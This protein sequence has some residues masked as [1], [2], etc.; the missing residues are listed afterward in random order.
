MG[1]A[2]ATV[3]AVAVGWW[4]GAV[5]LAI[6]T[7]VALVVFVRPFAELVSMPILRWFF[8]IES[9]GHLAD[10]PRNGGVLVI[11]NHAS[12]FDPPILVHELP[13]ETTGVMNADYADRWYFWFLARF[14]FRVIRVPSA[15]RK[16]ETPEVDAIVAALDRGQCV[17]L[18]PEGWL[19][20]KDEVPLRR[21]GQGIWRI[22]K[23][24]PQTTVVP[25]WIEGTWGSR[26]SYKDGPPAGPKPRDR[27]RPIRV[28]FGAPRTIP[29]ALLA[30]H[31]ATRFELMSWV[32]ETR[33][34][35]GLP[36]VAVEAVANAN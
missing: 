18:F 34:L 6:A 20:R 29:P 24:R 19:R 13:R 28:A 35:L 1:I 7:A 14:V 17:L 36:P 15:S 12:H 4:P 32:G 22:L 21:F 5:G 9:V 10:V 2:G 25:C 23:A 16:T 30:D 26:F 27:G 8:R 3:V 33:G 31:W 11:A